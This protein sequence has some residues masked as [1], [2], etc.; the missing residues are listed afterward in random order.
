MGDVVQ[1]RPAADV[2]TALRNIADDIEAG[3]YNGESVTVIAVPDVFQLGA[4]DDNGAVTETVFNLNYALHK[5][6]MYAMGIDL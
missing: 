5:I 2:V 4:F 6:M 3:L 1:L